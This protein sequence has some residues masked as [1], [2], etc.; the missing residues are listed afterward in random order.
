M[1]VM[2]YALKICF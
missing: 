2:K 1:I